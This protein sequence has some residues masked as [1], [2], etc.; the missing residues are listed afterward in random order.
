MFG[1]DRRGVVIG[2]VSDRSVILVPGHSVSASGVRMPVP[3]MISGTI[4]RSA[5]GRRSAVAWMVM[6]LGRAGAPMRAVGAIVATFSRNM[7]NN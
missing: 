5:S 3:L 7:P 1:R 2:R 4:Q 6:T